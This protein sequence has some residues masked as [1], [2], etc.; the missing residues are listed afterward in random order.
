MIYIEFYLF[1]FI[2]EQISQNKFNNFNL[3]KEKIEKIFIK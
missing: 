3:V 2:D 1:N